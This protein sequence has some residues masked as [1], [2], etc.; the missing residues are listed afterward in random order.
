[1]GTPARQ[2]TASPKDFPSRSGGLLFLRQAAD[3]FDL[4]RDQD[5]S[6]IGHHFPDDLL[7]PGVEL[8]A[9]FPA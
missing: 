5:L 1:M 7:E 6:E 8:L 4:L 2:G 3:P 9:E